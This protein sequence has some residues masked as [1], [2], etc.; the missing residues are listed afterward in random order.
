MDNFEE[1]GKIMCS[2]HFCHIS[3]KMLPFHGEVA[4]AINTVNTAQTAETINEPY[5]HSKI[6]ST[7]VSH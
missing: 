4:L 6:W 1:P 3:L 2:S 7:R 5:V